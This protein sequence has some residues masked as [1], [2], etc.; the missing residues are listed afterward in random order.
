MD[1]TAPRHSEQFPPPA[2]ARMALD[3]VYRDAAATRWYMQHVREISPTADVSVRGVPAVPFPEAPIA[4]DGLRLTRAGGGAWTLAEMLDGV[5]ADGILILRDGAIVYERYF[6]GMRRETPH[7]YQSITKA[8]G[9]CVAASL[10]DAGALSVDDAV[11]TIVP[12]LVGS[13]YDGATVRHLLDMSVAIAYDESVDRPELDGAR[14]CRLE[15]VQPSLSDDEPGS[16]YEFATTTERD[17]EHGRRFHYVS[18][19]T[20]VLGWVMERSTG[21]A[22]SELIR[23]HLWSRLGAE[24]DTYIALDGAGSAMLDGGFASSLRDLA[25]FGQMLCRSGEDHNGAQVVPTSWIEDVRRNGDKR[26][27]EAEAKS[28][29]NP[30]AYRGCSYRS[31]FWVLDAGDHVSFSGAGWL[32]Q[33]VHVSPEA[34]VVIALFSS[35]PQD[36]D[37][38]LGAHVFIACEEIA[39]AL[40]S[41][42]FAVDGSEPRAAR[43]ALGERARHVVGDHTA[44][45]GLGHDRRVIGRHEVPDDQIKTRT[46]YLGDQRLA[47]DLHV[48]EEHRCSAG[49]CALGC[50]LRV[51]FEDQPA[52]HLWREFGQLCEH[53]V[54]ERGDDQLAASRGEVGEQF[55]DVVGVAVLLEFGIDRDPSRRELE[56]L[57]EERWRRT[58]PGGDLGA[59][60]RRQGRSGKLC[61][62][63]DD[64]L[65]VA[66]APDVELDHVRPELDRPL[67]CLE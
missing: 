13:A 36:R 56:D 52:A 53:N 3:Q 17:G 26:A 58:R 60:Q 15:G 14:L 51:L 11:T 35:R 19:N 31:C 18:L 8:V 50:A 4:L 1:E 46:R 10:V 47:N 41:T 54:D 55:G 62:M 5:F 42:A 37:E 9:S 32:G 64:Q 30:A 40:G 16:T 12:E 57:F 2:V 38:E 65:V 61:V 44:D 27:F 6:N 43:D 28:W 63:E 25:R 48:R 7:L 66:R 29:T 22:V 33:R 34:G 20:L 24:H 23:R 21:L 59:R 67:E 39:Q 49:P 45:A